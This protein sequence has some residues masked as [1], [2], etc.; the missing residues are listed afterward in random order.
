M[1]KKNKLFYI[2]LV[3]EHNYNSHYRNVYL[4]ALSSWKVNI[5]KKIIVVMA[6]QAVLAPKRYIR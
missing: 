2:F 3:P 4:L 1:Q 6:V 5:A